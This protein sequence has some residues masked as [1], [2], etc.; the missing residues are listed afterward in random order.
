VQAAS[1]KLDSALAGMTGA[2]AK[3]AADAKAV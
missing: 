3:L 1:T 2:D